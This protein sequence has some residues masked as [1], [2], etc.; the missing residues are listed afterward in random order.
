MST[1]RPAP[2]FCR[3]SLSLACLL[4]CLLTCLPAL[5]LP[6]CLPPSCNRYWL[7]SL[8]PS[9]LNP[10]AVCKCLWG[11]TFGGF[12]LT[13]V[14]VVGWLCFSRPLLC[15]VYTAG[16]LRAGWLAGWLAA[17][18]STARRQAGRQSRRGCMCVRRTKCIVWHASFHS[19]THGFIHSFIP[20]IG[21]MSLFAY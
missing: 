18:H 10:L 12:T 5:P 19:L 11:W 20:S 2:P 8:P 14:V 21:S 7:P 15:T 9:R 17:R 4:A 16:L 3:P 1:V 13:I 6:P